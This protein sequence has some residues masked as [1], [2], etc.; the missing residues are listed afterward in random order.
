VTTA[1][2]QCD[3]CHQDILFVNELHPDFGY[4]RSIISLRQL[5]GQMELDNLGNRIPGGRTAGS[6]IEILNF[7]I[8]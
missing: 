3:S 4:L 2:E 7:R 5:R 1:S 8:I 6:R